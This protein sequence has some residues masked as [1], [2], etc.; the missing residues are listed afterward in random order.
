MCPAH[1]RGSDADLQE[2][3]H[4][5]AAALAVFSHLQSV[6]IRV[7]EEEL[8]ASQEDARAVREPLIVGCNRPLWTSLSKQE[9]KK[10]S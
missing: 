7:L 9:S 2:L 8:E 4:H 10:R 3:E 5:F 6:R 1:G